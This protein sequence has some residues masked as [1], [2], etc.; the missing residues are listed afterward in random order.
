[1]P[2]TTPADDPK[3][4]FAAG[5][6]LQSLG[7]ERR[8][9]AEGLARFEL[10]LESRHM[11]RLGIP[12]GGVYATMLD[13]AL[14]ASGCW[15]GAPDRFRPS[16]TLNLNVSYLAQPKGARLIAE[17]RRTGGGKSIYFAEGEVRDETGILVATAT[18]TFKVVTPR[19]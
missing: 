10:A 16:V 8:A 11:N 5:G 15:D 1:M 7:L 9:F 14:G 18:G 2:D 19:S 4:F 13:S 6:F 3:S 12:H 17:G